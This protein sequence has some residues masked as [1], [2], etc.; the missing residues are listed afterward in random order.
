MNFGAFYVWEGVWGMFPDMD[1][2][3]LNSL[4]NFV[5]KLDIWL[6]VFT[7]RDLLV[8]WP[9][10]RVLSRLSLG[11]SRLSLGLS[12]LGL[13]PPRLGL[14]LHCARD[15]NT[16]KKKSAGGGGYTFCPKKFCENACVVS[17]KKNPSPQLTLMRRAFLF[18]VQIYKKISH[19]V[20]ITPR[21]FLNGVFS[22]FPKQNV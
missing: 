2:L 21:N 11:L 7:R 3:F 12:V 14:G 1:K 22:T 18:Y 4:L 10:S 19:K 15:K 16:H 9:N 13:G 20:W 5:S 8:L 17:F 6:P